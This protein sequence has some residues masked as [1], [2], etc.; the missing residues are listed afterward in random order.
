[1]KRG[2]LDVQLIPAIMVLLFICVIVFAFFVISAEKLRENERG[3]IAI[4]E[5]STRVW[6]S[7]VMEAYLNMPLDEDPQKYHIPGETL[8]PS[9]PMPGK[10]MK[11]ILPEIFS[12]SECF[13]QLGGSGERM[14]MFQA[15]VFTRSRSGIGVA[16]YDNP[17]AGRYLRAYHLREPPT[18]LCTTFFYR[19]I[20]FM[21]TIS[22]NYYFYLTVQKPSLGD[23]DCYRVG[24]KDF[25]GWHVQNELLP[26]SWGCEGR[27]PEAISEWLSNPPWAR[28][29]IY[30]N[31]RFIPTEDG[32][33]VVRLTIADEH[34]RVIT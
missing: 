23:K 13:R 4:E 16:L 12:D 14:G 33:I 24:L 25:M 34:S 17:E 15:E 19:T 20:E 27:K 31:F 11:D 9:P 22:P 2:L 32:M 8:H 6:G 30:Q 5:Q 1:M 21:R 28:M 26:S 7:F 29:D 10:R 18:D 3:Q